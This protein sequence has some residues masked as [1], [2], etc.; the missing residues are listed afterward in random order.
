MTWRSTQVSARGGAWRAEKGEHHRANQS[1]Q[2]A[3]ESSLAKFSGALADYVMR[4]YT[5]EPQGKPDKEALD[6][7]K[8]VQDE[9]LNTPTPCFATPRPRRGHSPW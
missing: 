9:L 3:A 7:D 6:R 8:R 2:P 1:L 4:P 5:Q